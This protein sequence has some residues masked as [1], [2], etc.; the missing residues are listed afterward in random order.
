MASCVNSQTPPRAAKDGVQGGSLPS[1]VM[2][3]CKKKAVGELHRGSGGRQAFSSL[4]GSSGRQVRLWK[5]QPC[6]A[7]LA[8]AAGEIRGVIWNSSTVERLWIENDLFCVSRFS[9]VFLAVTTSVKAFQPGFIYF[10]FFPETCF[11]HLLR[12][13]GQV[14]MW[15]L[16]SLVYRE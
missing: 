6:S 3:P 1:L 16:V 12:T 14:L 13:W 8:R 2:K 9:K 4:V 15:T 5:H 11:F 7:A 10:F